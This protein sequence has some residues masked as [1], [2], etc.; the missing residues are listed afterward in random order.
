MLL[1]ATVQG[2]AVNYSDSLFVLLLMDSSDSPDAE[3]LHQACEQLAQS[4]TEKIAALLKVEAVAGIGSVRG[5]LDELIDSYLESRE[6]L[7][8]AEFQGASRV[9]PY[10]EWAQLHTTF[11]QYGPLLKQWS[12]ALTG[13]ELDKAAERWAAIHARLQQELSGSLTD[14]QTICVSLFSSL[15]FFWNDEFPQL[16]PPWTMSR[17]LQEIQ[18]QF[19]LHELT[20]WMDGLAQE[21]LH[22]S[23]QELSGRRSNRLVDRVKQYVGEHSARKS[24]LRRSRRSCS[25]I[26]NI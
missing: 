17:F 14:V 25:C 13:K 24:A 20:G 16:E 21:W 22:Q 15:M 19:T 7:A 3:E 18:Q 4:A 2:Y 5:G 12:E 8:A 23:M 6:A 10:R 11:D 9:Y 26:R 1:P